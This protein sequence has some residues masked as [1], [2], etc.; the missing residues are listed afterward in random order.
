MGSMNLCI[1]QWAH[2]QLCSYIGQGPKIPETQT[3]QVQM[4]TNQADAY[5]L[6]M[7]KVLTEF[8]T[9]HKMALSEQAKKV[10]KGKP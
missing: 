2:K 8:A 7:T 4:Q 6:S 3:Q 9:S 1:V 10:M 5:L